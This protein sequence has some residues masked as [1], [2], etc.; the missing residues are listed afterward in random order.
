MQDDNANEVRDLVRQLERKVAAIAAENGHEADLIYQYGYFISA[1]GNILSRT[2]S[3]RHIMLL[4][5]NI[6]NY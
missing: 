6:D 4:R 3:D 5:T 2:L 1:M